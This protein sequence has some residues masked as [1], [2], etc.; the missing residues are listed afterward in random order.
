MSDLG[1]ILEHAIGHAIDNA[2]GEHEGGLVTKWVALVESVNADGERGLWVMT[3]D[4]VTAWD[5]LG[6]LQY[7]H[8]VEL[9]A[10]LHPED[11]EPE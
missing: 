11:D 1:P 2:V 8:H 7:A 6:L 5:S 10:I 4:G 9:A 3:S